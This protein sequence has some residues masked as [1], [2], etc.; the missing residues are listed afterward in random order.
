M[1]SS[2]W[3]DIKRMKILIIK[4]WKLSKN[5]VTL[6]SRSI[7]VHKDENGPKNII[8]QQNLYPVN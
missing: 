4:L 5:K 7:Y 6:P 1:N 8:L 3:D 2:N